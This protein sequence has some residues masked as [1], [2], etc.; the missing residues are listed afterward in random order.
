MTI[1]GSFPVNQNNG[2][3]E[4]FVLKNHQNSLKGL[5]WGTIGSTLT[6]GALTLTAATVTTVAGTIFGLGV[7][8][9]FVPEFITRSLPLLAT[10]VTAMVVTDYLVVKGTGG[11]FSNAMYHLGPEYQIVKA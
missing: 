7:A 9:A 11:C 1:I 5:I 3:E 8:N 6:A 4:F 2:S 10:G